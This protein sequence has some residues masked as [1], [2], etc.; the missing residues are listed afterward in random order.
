VVQIDRRYQGLG[1]VG[2]TL[3]DDAELG[4]RILAYDSVAHD[5]FGFLPCEAD[6]ALGGRLTFA[7]A[8]VCEVLGLAGFA[9]VDFRVGGDGD[10][11]VIDVS[12]SPHIVRHSSYWAAF[13][14]R[15]WSH[16]EML[17]CMIAANGNRLGW[18]AS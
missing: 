7:A 17:A 14:K 11:R 13:E 5:S 3:D 16:A 9:R 12:T 6:D 18:F 2:I 8:R 1:P 10:A 4:N 15:G